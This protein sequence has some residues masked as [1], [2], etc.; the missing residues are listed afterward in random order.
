MFRQACQPGCGRVES[1]L[2]VWAGIS[3]SGFGIGE[4]RVLAG[5]GM[6]EVWIFNP[7]FSAPRLAI[8][9]DGMYVTDTISGCVL[10]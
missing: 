3:S 7:C 5:W 2:R 6:I 1:S 10:L 4:S 9:R 8:T